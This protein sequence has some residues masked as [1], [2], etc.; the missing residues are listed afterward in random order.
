MNPRAFWT[1]RQRMATMALVLLEA[2]IVTSTVL[3]A[4]EG[5]YGLA[6]LLLVALGLLWTF[7]ALAGIV[8]FCFARRAN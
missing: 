8:G 2:A 1:W 7:A 5:W 4:L 3:A 6:T